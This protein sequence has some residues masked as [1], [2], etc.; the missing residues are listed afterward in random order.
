MKKSLTPERELLVAKAQKKIK[1]ASKAKGP[2]RMIVYGRNGKGK[3]H[4]IGSSNLRTLIVDCNEQGVESVADRPNVDVYELSTWE[5]VDWVYWYLRNGDHPYE[6]IAIDTITMLANICMKWILHDEARE[7]MRDPMMPDRRHWGKLAQLMMNTII[8]W[9]NLPYHII[10]SAQERT[11]TTDDEDTGGTIIEV[12]PEISPAPRSTL[13]SAVGTI[14]RIYVKEVEK[15]GKKS[16]EW[17]MLVGPHEKYV[18]KTRI[19]GLPR[20]IRNPNL[21]K[22]LEIR[23][24]MGEVDPGEVAHAS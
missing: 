23:D 7:T 8:N 2:L 13:L 3:T 6:V 24:K 16:L 17:R 22:I 5:E 1:P 9:R 14:G 18:S 20:I 10:I 12:H 4:F 21:G 11:T 15:E 19:K